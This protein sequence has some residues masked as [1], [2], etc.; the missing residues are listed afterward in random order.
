KNMRVYAIKNPTRLDIPQYDMR[1]I[2]ES[3]VNAIIHRD[4]YNYKSKIRLHMF[5]DRLEIFSPGALA[6][7]MT[8]ENIPLLQA[9]RNELIASLIARCPI[10]PSEYIKSNRKNLMDKRGEGVPIILTKSKNLSGHI[11]E[12]R[13]IDQMELLLTIYATPPPN[14]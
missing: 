9:T 5:S 13:E 7:S 4:Y 10:N 2:L 8:I 11:P 6:N 3:I 1:A 14:I 12:Y